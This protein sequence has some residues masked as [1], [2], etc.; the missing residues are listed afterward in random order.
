L[1]D[2][3]ISKA[4]SRKIANNYSLGKPINNVIASSLFL[5][6]IASII[7]M[8][9]I[10]FVSKLYLDSIDLSQMQINTQ[11]LTYFIAIA[12]PIN[13]IVSILNGIFQGLKWF[14]ALNVINILTNSFFHILP[15]IGVILFNNGITETLFIM[16]CI[17]SVSIPVY[18]YFIYLKDF[19]K[20]LCISKKLLLE[21][22]TFGGWA[23]I[24]VIIGTLILTLDKLFITYTLGA[25][26]L[27]IYAVPFQLSEKLLLIANSFGNAIYPYYSQTDFNQKLLERYFLKFVLIISIITILGFVIGKLFL[28]LWLGQS[29]NSQ[30][31]NIFYIFLFSFY[32]QS[33]TVIP[34]TYLTGI[35]RPKLIAKYHII[36]F[37]IYI[38]FLSISI[39]YYGLIGAAYLFLIIKVLDLLIMMH[40]AVIFHHLR[41]KVYLYAICNFII[42]FIYV[43]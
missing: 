27:V 7:G 30:M 22:F 18:L 21:I 14:K 26:V 10:L 17:K 4:T 34:F 23:Y 35:S 32:I 31:I 25:S 11:L 38:S 9:F 3:G 39:E 24:S 19:F 37:I 40:L 29:F 15:L 20:E 5:G 6:L 33:L 13:I 12:F 1:F 16:L 42:M 28:E 41:K 43:I 2:F 36:L 8:L